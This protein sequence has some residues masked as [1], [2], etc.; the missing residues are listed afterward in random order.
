LLQLL[1]ANVDP[2]DLTVAAANV[3]HFSRFVRAEDW[4]RI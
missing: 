1:T 4:Q 3:G 2:D